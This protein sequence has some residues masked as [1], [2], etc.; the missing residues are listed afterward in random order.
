LENV[1]KMLCFFTEEKRG[2]LDIKNYV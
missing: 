2:Y 1:E